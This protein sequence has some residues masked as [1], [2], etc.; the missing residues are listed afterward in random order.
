MITV[1]DQYLQLITRGTDMKNRKIISA[2][3]AAIF[4]LYGCSSEK[5]NEQLTENDMIVSDTEPAEVVSETVP[6]VTT[7]VTEEI[8]EEDKTE[9]VNRITG[10]MYGYADK[11]PYIQKGTGKQRPD[12]YMPPKNYYNCTDAEITDPELKKI[13][14]DYIDRSLKE[15]ESDY[16]IFAGFYGLN[17][18][19][20]DIMEIRTNINVI[21]QY[22]T[23]ILQCMIRNTMEYERKTGNTR[24]NK[25]FEARTGYFD[26]SRKEQ[27]ELSDLFF[28]DVDFMKT[29]NDKYK[30]NIK[31][32]GKWFSGL[33]LEYTLFDPDGLGL[34]CPNISP[35]G[36]P[37]IYSIYRVYDIYDFL[38]DSVVYSDPVCYPDIISGEYKEAQFS[39]EILNFKFG[40]AEH[41]GFAY[42][43]LKSRIMSD[44]DIKKLTDKVAEDIGYKVYYENP[45]FD[46]DGNGYFSDQRVKQAVSLRYLPAEHC[47]LAS[48]TPEPVYRSYE[49]AYDAD[50]FER[51]SNEELISRLTGDSWKEHVDPDIAE[52]LNSMELIL[53]SNYAF[54]EMIYMTV[55]DTEKDEEH[56]IRISYSEKDGNTDTD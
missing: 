18:N 24:Y 13:T 17:D 23:V 54:E 10:L 38:S 56:S 53:Y 49:C 8:T 2:V 25:L 14:D 28:K 52:R 51:M 20:S 40:P 11:E 36:D 41:D 19:M 29:I 3:L 43:P 42:F 55:I 50:T 26:I 1:K 35:Y 5:N 4:L 15:I 30:E 31:L 9:T 33:N 27:I 37:D 21:N 12:D 48:I 34:L 16:K 7:A 46:N 45:L 39:F 6:V 44:D 32:K 22:C 47:F